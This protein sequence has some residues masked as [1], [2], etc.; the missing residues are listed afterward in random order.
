MRGH[1]DQVAASGLCRFDNRSGR[2]CIRNMQEFCGNPILL[3]HISSF[4]EH[5]ARTFLAGCV[6]AINLFRRWNPPPGVSA[7]KVDG[8]RG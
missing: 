6:K 4:I 1:D 7:A 2:V 5:F 8:Q 3:G